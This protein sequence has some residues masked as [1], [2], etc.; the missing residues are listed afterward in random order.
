MTATVKS[1]LLLTV[2]FFTETSA[3]RPEAEQADV[4]LDM[5]FAKQN[6]GVF[7]KGVVSHG[8]IAG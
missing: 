5:L 1:L 6:Q 8:K 7:P 4:I 3:G 2:G